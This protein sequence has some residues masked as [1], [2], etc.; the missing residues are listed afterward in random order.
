[1]KKSRICILKKVYE[2]YVKNI[3]EKHVKFVNFSSIQPNPA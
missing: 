3:Y 1:M 2:K